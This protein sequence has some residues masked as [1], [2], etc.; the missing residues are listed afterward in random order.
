MQYPQAE[1]LKGK[2]TLGENVG[3]NRYKLNDE[4][5]MNLTKFICGEMLVPKVIAV[6]HPYFIFEI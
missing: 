1:C 5:L 2:V 3:R 6:G 4:R